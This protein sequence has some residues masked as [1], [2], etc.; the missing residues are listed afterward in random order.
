[1]NSTIPGCGFH[2]VAIRSAKFDETVK[3]YT[4]V[5]GFKRSALWGE[6][7]SRGTLLDTGDGNYVEIFASETEPPKGEGHWFHVAF[8]TT[9]VKLAL[10]RARAAGA[11]ITMEVR[12]IVIEDAERNIPIRIGFCTGPNGESIEFFENSLT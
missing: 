4:E 11:E 8:R 12:D 10:E 6:G 3:F 2:H 5:L 9:D 1:M 7:N